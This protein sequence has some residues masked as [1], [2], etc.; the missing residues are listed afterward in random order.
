[1]HEGD[2]SLI[3][4]VCLVTASSRQYKTYVPLFVL[5]AAGTLILCSLLF[6]RDDEQIKLLLTRT[7]RIPLSFNWLEC[8]SCLMIIVFWTD[9]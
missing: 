1:M 9:S 7:I 4:A 3:A 6:L 5:W 8:S 2:V